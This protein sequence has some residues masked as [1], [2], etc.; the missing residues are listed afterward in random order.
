MGRASFQKDG[1]C[2]EGALGP[3]GLEGRKRLAG[4]RGAVGEEEVGAATENH[5]LD[6]WGWA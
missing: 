4:G 3:Q 2:R 6:R 5:S 1:C